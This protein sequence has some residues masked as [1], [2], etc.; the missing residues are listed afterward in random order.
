MPRGIHRSGPDCRKMP[1]TSRTSFLSSSAGPDDLRRSSYLTS[2]RSRT[3]THLG[4]CRGFRR[5]FRRW[6]E[7]FIW[8]AQ[9]SQRRVLMYNRAREMNNI[10]VRARWCRGWGCEKSGDFFGILSAW[11]SACGTRGRRSATGAFTNGC[12][13]RQDADARELF[14][15]VYTYIDIHFRSGRGNRGVDLVRTARLPTG[16]NARDCLLA[17]RTGIADPRR[18]QVESLTCVGQPFKADGDVPVD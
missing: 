17:R 6:R 2:S 11:K 9:R 18:C 8:C 1:G 13:E 16:S 15:G 5:S 7:L 12:G 14:F 10:H 3:T 4:N